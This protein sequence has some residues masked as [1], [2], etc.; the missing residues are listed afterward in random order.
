MLVSDILTIRFAAFAVT[1]L[2][3]L[4]LTVRVWKTADPMWFKV[5]LTFIVFVPFVGPVFILW[6]LNFP[7]AMHPSMQ[8][9]YK[10]QLNSYSFP[11]T[12]TKEHE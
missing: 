8:A 4:Y 7:N 11:T 10:N 5:L 3:A 12:R 6:N 1:T 9:K 2:L